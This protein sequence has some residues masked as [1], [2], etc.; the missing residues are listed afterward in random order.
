MGLTIRRGFPKP[1]AG[2]QN[3]QALVQR[4]LQLALV[5]MAL[6]IAL[7]QSGSAKWAMAAMS[8]VEKQTQRRLAQLWPPRSP[9]PSSSSSSSSSSSPS[10]PSSPSSSSSPSWWAWHDHH[11]SPG[12]RHREEFPN[13]QMGSIPTLLGNPRCP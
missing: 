7:L 4:P 8:P 2:L 9:P 5:R 13:P 12:F 1:S 3:Q 6:A 11:D 10:S